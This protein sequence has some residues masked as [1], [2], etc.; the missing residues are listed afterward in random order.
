MKQIN[1]KYIDLFSL[2]APDIAQSPVNITRHAIIFR[3]SG[4]SQRRN[5]FPSWPQS[6]PL[7]AKRAKVIATSP[8]LELRWKI[9]RM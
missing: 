1:K 2:Y 6:Q 7:L 5:L 8:P 4:F 9:V 3:V